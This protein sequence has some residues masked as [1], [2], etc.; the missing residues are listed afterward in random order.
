[1]E[2]LEYDQPRSRSV[3][4]FPCSKHK[5]F[6]KYLIKLY[7]ARQ[8]DLKLVTVI[9]LTIVVT[10]HPLLQEKKNVLALLRVLLLRAEKAAVPDL[11]ADPLNVPEDT[12]GIV[13]RFRFSLAYNCSVL[14]EGEKQGK[15]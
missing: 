5:Q 15:S 11:V 14:S 3:C 4:R 2:D 1:M 7:S 13:Q 8:C 12:E 6:V 10:A 9:L